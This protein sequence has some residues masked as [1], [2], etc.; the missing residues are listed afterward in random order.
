L[1]DRRVSGKSTFARELGQRL[2]LPVTH[3][4]ALY[5]RPGWVAPPLEEWRAQV[6]QVAERD[7]WIIDGNYSDTIDLRFARADTIIFLD[8]PRRTYLRRVLLRTLRYRGQIR[9]DS[10]IPLPL[11]LNG[12]IGSS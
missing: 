11:A 3:L 5:W 7:S 12:S 9:P 6:R 8:L 2:G 4:D 10:A 1:S